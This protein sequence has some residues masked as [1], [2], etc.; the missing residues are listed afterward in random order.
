MI[1]IAKKIQMK[2]YCVKVKYNI[3]NYPIFIIVLFDMAYKNLL[4]YKDNIY[5]NIEDIIFLNIN[6]EYKL[7]G[8]ISIPNFNHYCCVIFN[9]R[10][11]YLND[12]FQSNYIYYHDGMLNEGKISKIKEGEDWRDL[13]IH[14]ILIYQLINI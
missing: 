8:I 4:K 1:V 13:G 7:K 9:L 2:I 12:Y 11:S 5:N 10:G 14:Y 3:E 6:K